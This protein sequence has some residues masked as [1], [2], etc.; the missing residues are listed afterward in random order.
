MYRT[1]TTHQDTKQGPRA[2]L[3]NVERFGRSGRMWQ[4]DEASKTEGVRC[5][6]VDH[7]INGVMLAKGGQSGHWALISDYVIIY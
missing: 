1:L 7:N 6:C 3:Q 4:D 5:M 2:F